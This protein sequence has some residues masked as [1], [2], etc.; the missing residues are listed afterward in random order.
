MVVSFLYPHTA[1][2]NNFKKSGTQLIFIA[3]HVAQNALP[4][5]IVRVY[6]LRYLSLY[7]KISLKRYHNTRKI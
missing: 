3:L 7:P 2:Y 1:L 5:D 6:I 4:E